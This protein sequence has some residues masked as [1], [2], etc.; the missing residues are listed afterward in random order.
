MQV[1]SHHLQQAACCT[2][3]LMLRLLLQLS[4]RCLLVVSMV[5]CDGGDGINYQQCWCIALALGMKT[6][7]IIAGRGFGRSEMLHA[8]AVVV[9]G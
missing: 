8:G 7:R 5:L 3:A 6:P 9:G 1:H 2:C 4:W